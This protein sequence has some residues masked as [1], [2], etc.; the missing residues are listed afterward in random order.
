MMIRTRYFFETEADGWCEYSSRA[1]A[2]RNAEIA[3]WSE[4][5][6]VKTIRD[7]VIGKTVHVAGQSKPT[8]TER[9]MRP[10]IWGY[11]D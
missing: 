7:G 3:A 6:E 5:V 1:S 4:Q 9:C 11:L 2:I 8:H 10:D